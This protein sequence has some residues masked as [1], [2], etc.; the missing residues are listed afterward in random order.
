LLDHRA[1]KAAPQMRSLEFHM[2]SG[3][4]EIYSAALAAQRLPTVPIWRTDPEEVSDA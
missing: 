4:I 2:P 1:V 3:K